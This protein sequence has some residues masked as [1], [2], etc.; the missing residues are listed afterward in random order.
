MTH[1]DSEQDGGTAGGGTLVTLPSARVNLPAL[2][3]LANV[4]EIGRKLNVESLISI[5]AI[6]LS[7]GFLGIGLFLVWKNLD[8]DVPFFYFIPAD[9]I[10]LGYMMGIGTWLEAEE[11]QGGG[12]ISARSVMRWIF[13]LTSLS[14]DAAGLYMHGQKWS[15]PITTLF[16]C[17]F[18]GP[19]QLA[20]FAVVIGCY[21]NCKTD[22]LKGD[23]VSC[24]RKGTS[25]AVMA[26]MIIASIIVSL[27]NTFNVVLTL[28]ELDIWMNM[29]GLSITVLGSLLVMVCFV[30]SV[31]EW[32]D[33][34][35]DG[36]TLK[37]RSNSDED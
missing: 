28:N 13:C 33:R 16:V 32:N 6:I 34:G 31:D 18:G 24:K 36:S 12:T 9:V 7:A 21:S 11:L 26:L 14:F 10:L 1:I 35:I 5:L 17:S 19:L 25:R 2:V 27:V 20:F 4:N 37:A 29:A 23:E 15:D 3:S 30:K 22:I 8:A